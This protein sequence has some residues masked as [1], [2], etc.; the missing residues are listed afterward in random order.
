MLA[1]EELVEITPELLYTPAATDEAGVAV[2][3]EDD[4]LLLLCAVDEVE[5]PELIAGVCAD[6]VS[7]VA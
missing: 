4:G 3:A 5:P 7:V 2:L 1:Q 6:D